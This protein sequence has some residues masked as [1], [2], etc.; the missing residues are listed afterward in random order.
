MSLFTHVSH[1]AGQPGTSTH[2]HTITQTQF[3]I[4]AQLFI[5]ICLWGHLPIRVSVCVW[6]EWLCGCVFISPL[7]TY[8][9]H[10]PFVCHCGTVL[11]DSS[12][13]ISPGADSSLLD[14]ACKSSCWSRNHTRAHTLKDRP[15]ASVYLKVGVIVCVLNVKHTSRAVPYVR[16]SSLC[17]TAQQEY[18]LLPYRDYVGT[19]QGETP[20]YNIMFWQ[21]CTQL[22]EDI[23]RD[24]EVQRGLMLISP[25]RGHSQIEAEPKSL[26]PF[27]YL[28][29]NRVNMLVI[30]I[31]PEG[32]A[33]IKSLPVV[34]PSERY[35]G[36]KW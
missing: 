18:R 25:L 9:K 17:K 22:D 23:L 21:C 5:C 31:K 12:P 16:E 11:L 19:S 33:N 10:T 6:C 2:S 30:S 36:I 32:S 28:K 3:L 8:W 4:V 13:G 24:R 34:E 27:G 29:N 1:S 7:L 20:G 15:T 14:S 35:C 26:W